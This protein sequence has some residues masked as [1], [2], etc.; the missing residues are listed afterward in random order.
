[1]MEAETLPSGNANRRRSLEQGYS[2]D[3][4]TVKKHTFFMF[5]VFFP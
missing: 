3:L 5:L 2:S 4:C 1:M